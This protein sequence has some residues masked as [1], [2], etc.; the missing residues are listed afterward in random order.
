MSKLTVSTTI[1]ATHDTDGLQQSP[2]WKRSVDALVESV[3]TERHIL[4]PGQSRVFFSPVMESM[5][6]PGMTITAVEHPIKDG[7]VQLRSAGISSGAVVGS[8]GIGNHY[9]ISPVGDGTVVLSSGTDQMDSYSIGDKIYLPGTMYGDSDLWAAANQGF[10]IVRTK[11]TAGIV[12]RR[13]D[14]DIATLGVAET[15]TSTSVTD[16]QTVGQARYLYLDGDIYSGIWEIVEQSVGCVSIRPGYVIEQTVSF[17]VIYQCSNYAS[18]VRV[19]SDRS[20]LLSSEMDNTETV[21][22]AVVTPVIEGDSR[23][24]GWF[25]THGFIPT[26]SVRNLST[27]PANVAVILAYGKATA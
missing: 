25:E 8:A 10:W 16:I 27:E 12:L 6:S 1:L 21:L 13:A 9:S 7:V 4:A 23:S 17:D 5:V 11:T 3:D 15:I 24:V 20:V 18:Y 22:H 14:G 2:N 26:L 19:E